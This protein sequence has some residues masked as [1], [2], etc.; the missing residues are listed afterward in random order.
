MALV[1]KATNRFNGLVYIGSTS[2]TLECR[3][4]SH[5]YNNGC[6]MFHE[7]ID[8][9][10]FD[11]FSWVILFVSENN[12]E[13]HKKEMYF[14]DKYES[15]KPEFGYN[16]LRAGGVPNEET[17]RKI[18]EANK[19]SIGW[20]EGKKF[21]EETRRKISE[22]NKGFKRSEEAKRKIGEANRR[23]IISEETKRKISEA[24]KGVECKGLA[25]YNKQKKGKILEEIYGAEKAEE[26]RRKL[27]EAQ[28]N[29]KKWLGRKHSE[30]EKR[31]IS[32]ANKG[33][34]LSEEH[35]RKIS[36]KRKGKKH[37]EETKIK[38]RKPRNKKKIN[39]QQLSS[40]VSLVVSKIIA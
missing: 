32:E 10:G 39:V 22:A 16:I 7:A 27:S 35:K 17:R 26:I 36:E 20:W 6:R 40:A 4:N 38:M 18:S 15:Y 30:E 19:G 29:N 12:Y 21:S 13:I 11:S 2:R 24:R 3:K 14:I 5:K 8:Y 37:S 25:R 23:R 31:K 33:K 28:K 1:Y 9:Y 34:K